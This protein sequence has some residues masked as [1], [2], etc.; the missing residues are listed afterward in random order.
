MYSRNHFETGASSERAGKKNFIFS[1]LEQLQKTA[2]TAIPKDW[3]NSKKQN[4]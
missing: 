2:K 3:L 1:Y 4:T